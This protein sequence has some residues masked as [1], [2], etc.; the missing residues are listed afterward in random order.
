MIHSRTNPEI[1]NFKGINIRD[2]MRESS[3]EFQNSRY[4]KKK[5]AH[6]RTASFESVELPNIEETNSPFE[7]IKKRTQKRIGRKDLFGQNF[8]HMNVRNRALIKANYIDSEENQLIG[9]ENYEE[10]ADYRSQEYQS[11]TKKKYG[12]FFFFGF[13]LNLNFEDFVIFFKT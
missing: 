7:K 10:L 4:S 13:F 8:Q 6:Y 9:Y 12:F 3:Q 2:L 5:P 1:Q 11:K